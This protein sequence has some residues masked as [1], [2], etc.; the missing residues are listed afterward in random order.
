MAADLAQPAELTKANLHPYRLKVKKFRDVIAMSAGGGDPKFA[1]A[2]AKCKDAI[3]EWHDWEELIAI[4][5]QAT[6]SRASLLAIGRIESH[7]QT[8]IGRGV[9]HRRQIP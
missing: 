7:Q 9:I 8:Q 5:R 2:L 4:A 3:G 1:D 6:A